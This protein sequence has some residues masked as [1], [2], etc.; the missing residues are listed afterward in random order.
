MSLRVVLI[1]LTGMAVSAV[2]LVAFKGGVSMSVRPNDSE[3]VTRLSASEVH[4]SAN[5]ETATFALG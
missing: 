1:F 5:F 3:A 4:F 2:T